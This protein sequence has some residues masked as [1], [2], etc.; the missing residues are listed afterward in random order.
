MYKKRTTPVSL[1]NRIQSI[2]TMRFPCQVYG[3]LL[4]TSKYKPPKVPLTRE[5]ISRR[6]TVHC[7]GGIAQVV[8]DRQPSTLS[9]HKSARMEPTPATFVLHFASMYL[10]FDVSTFKLPPDM[11]NSMYI[12]RFIS[13]VVAL[14]CAV[15]ASTSPSD[16]PSDQ[17]AEVL[18]S[19]NH[20]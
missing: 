1:T 12:S 17:L 16:D 3:L 18:Q 15:N 6:Q 5:A 19:S 2:S 13:K 11:S 9:C 4:K 8:T 7:T 10:Y 14:N 20:L